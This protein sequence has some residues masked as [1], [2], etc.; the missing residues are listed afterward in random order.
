MSAAER[1][2]TAWEIEAALQLARDAKYWTDALAWIPEQWA[3]GKRL[4]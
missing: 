3:M 4:E 2:C 1:Q